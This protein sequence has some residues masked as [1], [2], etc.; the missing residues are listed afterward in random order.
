M[1]Y[2]RCSITGLYPAETEIHGDTQRLRRNTNPSGASSI[3]IIAEVR[4]PGITEKV[5]TPKPYHPPHPQ[6]TTD[7]QDVLKIVIWHLLPSDY[8]GLSATELRDRLRRQEHE[9]LIHQCSLKGFQS[10]IYTALNE[11]MSVFRKRL[12]LPH[13]KFHRVRLLVSTVQWKT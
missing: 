9:L 12:P 11:M 3:E 5:P 8:P 13:R 6:T 7:P 2:P 10:A 4:R 1:R